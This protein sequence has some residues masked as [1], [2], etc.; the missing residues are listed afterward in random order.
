MH[1]KT[2][3]T[4]IENELAAGFRNRMK[5][6][7]GVRDVQQIFAEFLRD[8]LS[9][10][11][12]AEVV[13]DEGDVRVDPGVEDGFV[14]GPGVAQNPDF[15]NFLHN[16]DLLDVLRRQGQ[17]AANKLKH[18]GRHSERDETKLFPRKDRKL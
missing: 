18:L 9:R 5:G 12:G 8:I 4:K 1:S 3:V 2:S 7:E 15:T 11:T 16:T 6:A 10:I 17:H 14:L 13:L